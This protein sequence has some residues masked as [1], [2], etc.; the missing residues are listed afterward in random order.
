MSLGKRMRTRVRGRF[1]EKFRDGIRR[2]RAV[3]FGR[4]RVGFRGKMRQIRR[5]EKERE[6]QEWKEREDG[7]EVDRGREK[8]LS[9]RD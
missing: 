7:R 2:Y 4:K 9:M 8:R 5:S 1:H 6:E 3:E